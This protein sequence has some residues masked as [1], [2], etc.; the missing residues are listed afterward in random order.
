MVSA[1]QGMQRP[2]GRLARALR[3][4]YGGALAAAAAAR[5]ALARA[6]GCGVRV[7]KAAQAEALRA[8]LAGAAARSRAAGRPARRREDPDRVHAE[9]IYGELGLLGFPPPG[10]LRDS[11]R[12]AGEPSLVPAGSRGERL[13]DLDE[14]LL[15]LDERL[16]G[17]DERLT[18]LL[19]FA[20]RPAADARHREA[21][22]DAREIGR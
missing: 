17:V 1:G 12:A 15:D 11:A 22:G 4:L 8:C 18:G 21:L 13:L 2:G 16:T 7:D 5:A 20:R 14:R 3:A 19:G 10:W 9:V 6:G